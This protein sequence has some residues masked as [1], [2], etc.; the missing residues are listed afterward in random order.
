[1]VGPRA[2]CD[3][4]W[5]AWSGSRAWIRRYDQRLYVRRSLASDTGDAPPGF[6]RAIERD[7]D[8]IA[9]Q[10]AAMEIED[11]GVDPR[12]DGLA[13]HRAAV[14][15]RVRSGRTWVIE[16]QG[17]IVFQV[18]AGTLSERG[19]QLGGTYVPPSQRGRGWGRA[20][21]RAV[22]AQ[23]LRRCPLVTLH[24]NESN[25]PAVRAYEASGFIADAPMRLITVRGSS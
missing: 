25:R 13:A 16:A 7:I 11:L 6:R 12:A 18:H 4:L 1:M 23:L 15:E 22:S 9:D 19:C 24:V 20:G 3:A 2:D 8:R 10:A 17:E 14:Q 21:M 5:S